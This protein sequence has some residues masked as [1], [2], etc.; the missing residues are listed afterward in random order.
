M[1]GNG[2][3]EKRH[4]ELKKSKLLQWRGLSGR[5]MGLEIRKKVGLA[6]GLGSPQCMK[7]KLWNN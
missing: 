6:L 3:L 2:G 5:S 7:L 4:R 1:A